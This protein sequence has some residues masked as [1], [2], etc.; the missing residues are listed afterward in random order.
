MPLKNGVSRSTISSNIRMLMN[1]NYPRAQAVAIALNH[2]R[3]W[4]EKNLSG[5]RRKAA[6]AKLRRK[7]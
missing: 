1:E 5:E 2:A 3:R 7:K 4:I 6:L